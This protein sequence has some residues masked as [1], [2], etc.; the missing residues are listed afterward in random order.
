MSVAQSEHLFL[1][2]VFDSIAVVAPRKKKIFFRGE[3]TATRRLAWRGFEPMT[4]AIMV[5]SSS[6]K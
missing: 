4:S 3:G 6:T 5:Q 2:D 1:G